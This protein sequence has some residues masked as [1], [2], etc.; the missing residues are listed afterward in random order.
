MLRTRSPG[1]RS[2]GFVRGSN[3][4]VFL[5]VQGEST[6]YLLISPLLFLASIS[7]ETF[8]LN[9]LCAIQACAP[10]ST[11]TSRLHTSLITR[12]NFKLNPIHCQPSSIAHY[13]Q[14]A[15]NTSQRGMKE[16]TG[17]TEKCREQEYPDQWKP[18]ITQPNKQRGP[19][20]PALYRQTPTVSE[21]PAT[22]NQVYRITHALSSQSI[23]PFHVQSTTT[24][25]QPW[26]DK[27]S[28]S[29]VIPISR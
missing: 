20:I 6:S 5:L 8:L 25:G 13:L 19:D 9:G 15:L 3:Y 24:S 18:W 2:S 27:A 26:G 7:C 23:I 10:V 21:T 1:H 29:H 22:I 14:V 17:M 16:S 4:E 11:S 12:S 28:S